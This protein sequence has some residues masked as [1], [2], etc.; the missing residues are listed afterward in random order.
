M[1]TS[2]RTERCS[3]GRALLGL[4]EQVCTAEDLLLCSQFI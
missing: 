1:S 2:Q 3:R 4:E